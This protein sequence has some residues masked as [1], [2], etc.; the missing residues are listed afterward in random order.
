MQGFSLS[1]APV[2]HRLHANSNCVTAITSHY[3][4]DCSFV[5]WWVVWQIQYQPTLAPLSVE[6]RTKLRENNSQPRENPWAGGNFLKLSTAGRASGRYGYNL[7]KRRSK[8]RTPRMPGIK[9]KTKRRRTN[10]RL[11]ENGGSAANI[12]RS[13]AYMAEGQRLTRTGS[14]ALNVRTMQCIWSSELFRILEYDPSSTDPSILA[15]LERVHPS[16]RAAIQQNI[17]LAI[18]TGKDF[19]HDYRL[20]L[21]DGT[22]KHIHSTGHPV[23]NKLGEIGEIVGAAADITDRAYAERALKRSEFYLAEAEKISRTGCWA[24]NT[25]TGEL[26]WSQEEWRIFGLDPRKTEISYQ[27]FLNLIHPDDRPS[28]QM[29][30]ADAVRSGKPYDIP[31]RIIFNDGS[32]RHLHMVGTPVLDE[33]GQVK[34]YIGVTTDVTDRKRTEVALQEAQS[35]LA[36]VARLTTMGEFAASIAHEINQPLAAIVA[37]GQAARRWLNRD[38]PNLLEAQE[39]I[40]NAVNSANRA[41]E[42]LTRIRT[43]LRNEKPEYLAIDINSVIRDVLTLTNS[44]LQA[45]NVVVRTR[46]PEDLPPVRGDRVGLQQVIMNLITNSTDAMSSITDR[47]RILRIESQIEVPDSVLVAVADTGTGFDPGIADRIFDRLFTTK[48]NGMGLGLSICQSIIEAHGGRLWAS[49]GS[50]HGV[51]FKF[52]MPIREQAA[53]VKDNI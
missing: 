8:L 49:P 39:A 1:R 44:T 40:T 25:T 23:K 32:I 26:F 13:E 15:F 30:S 51:V 7:R 28:V 4:G 27:V 52:T 9:S 20:L 19:A 10:R 35:E 2:L 31:Y 24:R 22:I 53:M 18:Q 47:S 11:G 42:V 16:D 6:D 14:W 36:R 12:R 43:L 48:P 34:E 41:S 38:V 46:L 21:G 45:R 5:G 29:I 17:D 37:Q 33:F 3:Q 50:P